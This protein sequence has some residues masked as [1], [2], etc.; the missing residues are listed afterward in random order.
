MGQARGTITQE[1]LEKYGGANIMLMNTGD[2]VG[3]SGGS[4]VG[5][6]EYEWVLR[7]TDEGFSGIGWNPAGYDEVYQLEEAYHAG[8][9]ESVLHSNNVGANLANALSGFPLYVQNGCGG[10]REIQ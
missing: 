3:S 10:L 4:T 2:E 7:W 5:T 6:G 1:E 9:L 8:N